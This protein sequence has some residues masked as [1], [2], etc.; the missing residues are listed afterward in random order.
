MHD[1]WKKESDFCLFSDARDIGLFRRKNFD[2]H[3]WHASRAAG[4]ETDGCGQDRG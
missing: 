2:L 3:R 4:A 1:F